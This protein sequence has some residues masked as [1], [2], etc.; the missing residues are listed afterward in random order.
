MTSPSPELRKLYLRVVR[1]VHPDGA[2]DGQDW[3]RCEHLTQEANHAYA[4]GDEGAF[5]AVLE[6]KLPDGIRGG[7]P[8]ARSYWGGKPS[9]A[10]RGKWQE[11]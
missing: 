3:L 5:R 2:I 1:R 8:G 10:N 6:P 9:Y 4:V 7:Q 11:R